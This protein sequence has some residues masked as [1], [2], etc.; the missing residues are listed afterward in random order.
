[1]NTFI[2]KLTNPSAI[3]NLHPH[4]TTGTP[5]TLNNYVI[6]KTLL[7]R[8]EVMGIPGVQSVEYDSKIDLEY[9]SVIQENAPQWALPWISNESTRYQNTRSGT[10]V[11]IYIVDTGVRDTHQEFGNRVRNLWS[12]DDVFWST[13]GEVSPT[14]GT[15]VAACAAGSTYGTAKNANIVN[16]RIDFLNST[17]VKALDVILYD[18]LM[19]DSKR[20]SIVNFSGASPLPM[21]GEI[22]DELTEFGIVPVAASGNNGESTPRFPAASWWVIAVGSIDE[23]GSPSYFTN[24]KCEIY[25]PGNRIT[26]AHVSSDAASSVTSGTSF[27]S[28]YVA[29]L[30]ACHLEGSDRFNTRTQVSNFQ[31]NY[32]SNLSDGDRIAP[33]DNGGYAVKTATSRRTLQVDWYDNI[34][35]NYSN[36]EIYEFVMAN[37]DNPAFIAEAAK[38]GNVDVNRLSNVL[39]YTVDEINQWF[40][41]H[42]VRTWWMTDAFWEENTESSISGSVENSG[43]NTINDTTIRKYIT[44]TVYAITAILLLLGIIF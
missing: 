28:P 13:T 8:M 23:D 2:V 32:Y 39:G 43:I 20:P 31:F 35:L 22:F 40:V 26:T 11:D 7:S 27:S 38:A 6:F 25:A 42:N 16:V 37:L 36:Q 29:G 21:I 4:G 15:S 33:F 10:G 3:S 24:R 44:N 12:Y 1:M 14:H 17:L 19:K 30:M 34:S 41:D 5:K 18:H 9:D